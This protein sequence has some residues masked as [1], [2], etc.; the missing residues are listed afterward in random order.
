MD[1]IV[2]NLDKTDK[3]KLG[4]KWQKKWAKT[5]NQ[6]NWK[7]C[8][9]EKW[10]W[11]QMESLKNWKIQKM[12]IQ[13]KLLQTWKLKNDQKILCKTRFFKCKNQN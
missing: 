11:D 7:L 5:E 4:Q 12:D 3:L 1:K 6:K 9:N 13:L 2:H 10:K 8:K